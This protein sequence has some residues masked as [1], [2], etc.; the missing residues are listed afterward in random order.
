M[1]GKRWII[2]TVIAITVFLIV[3]LIFMSSGS[4]QLETE[5]QKSGYTTENEE[6]AFYKKI[7]TNNTLDDYYNDLANKTNSEYEEYYFAK[8]SYDFIELKM[9]YQNEENKVLNISTNLKN[10]ETNYNFEVSNNKKY[11][12]LEGNNTDE[13]S[14]HIIR[15]DDMTSAEINNY[16]EE[17]KIE[18]QQFENRKNELLQNKKVKEIIQ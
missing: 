3:V 6:E 11:L 2:P 13:Y 18:I 4:N 9:S 16:C 7:V 12:L 1:K 14:C 17:I 8:E 15:N 5:L 10:V